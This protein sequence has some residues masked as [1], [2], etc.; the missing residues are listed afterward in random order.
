MRWAPA[1]GLLFQ[2]ACGV[3]MSAKRR[4]ILPPQM[5]GK[6]LLSQSSSKYS[7]SWRS[8][9]MKEKMQISERIWHPMVLLQS[10]VLFKSMAKV[11]LWRLSVP[12]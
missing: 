4:Q 12:N 6:M 8:L 7:L 2:Y 3:P 9:I 11:I 5:L 1:Y 10:M